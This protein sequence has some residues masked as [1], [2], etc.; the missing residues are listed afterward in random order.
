MVFISENWIEKN[1]N[2]KDDSHHV[3]KLHAFQSV[4]IFVA[5]NDL[6]VNF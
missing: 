2:V 5:Y 6:L 3:E 1:H 4:Q